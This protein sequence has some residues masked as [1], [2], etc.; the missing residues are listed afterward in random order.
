MNPFSDV[1]NL[2]IKCVYRF[3]FFAK[4]FSN[5]TISAYKIHIKNLYD[6]NKLD[7]SYGSCL[8]RIFL[9]YDSQIN[10]RQGLFDIFS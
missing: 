1:S 4:K 2:N 5:L 10:G 3:T 8:L 6:S 9:D 7:I